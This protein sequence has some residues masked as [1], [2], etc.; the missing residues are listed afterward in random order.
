MRIIPFLPTVLLV[1]CGVAAPLAAASAGSPAAAAVPGSETVRDAEL[2]KLGSW[3]AG[4]YA[5]TA[6]SI[7]DPAFFDVRL[8]IARIWRWRSDAVW[9]Y[10][11]QAMATHLDAPYRQRVYR[12][13]RVAADRF[14][15]AIF[16]LP[17]PDAAI[18][19]WKSANPLPSLNP[20]SLN[21]RAG[22]GV[23][24]AR[25]A[26]GYVGGTE[27]LACGSDI[28]GATYATSEV[29]V[30]GRRVISWDRGYDASGRQ[31]WGAR[32]G[33]YV[34]DKL[35]VAVGQAVKP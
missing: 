23:F 10:V 9:L 8:H 27:G 35:P 7:A 22:C 28:N 1:G 16:T 14:E 5:S 3:M 34:F 24:L 19:A 12:L 30:D 18:G 21:D 15:S 29:S 6:Q 2:V 33:G 31:V 25:T 4:S 11:E 26:A 17:D 13:T 20:A 32:K